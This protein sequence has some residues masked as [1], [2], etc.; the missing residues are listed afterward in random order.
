MRYVQN[1]P[2]DVREMLETIGVRSVD[3]LFRSVP[4]E[5]L[6]PRDFPFPPR[7]TD[8]ELLDH[9]RAVAAKHVALGSR[10]SF[11][12]AGAYRHFI[13]PVVDALASRGEFLTAYTPYQ[14][15][16]SQG[17][18]QAFFEF[19]TMICELTGLDVANAS[20]YDG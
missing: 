12:G 8:L 7:L 2:D 15:E 19:Q 5:L 14:P 9:L 4:A 3:D 18:L 10:P 6:A 16:A 17:S 11:L 20:L 13:P 1:T